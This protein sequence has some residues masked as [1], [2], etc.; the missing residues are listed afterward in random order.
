M[1]DLLMLIS[2]PKTFFCTFNDSKIQK[3]IVHLKHHTKNGNCSSVFVLV[4]VCLGT[5]LWSMMTV[6]SKINQLDYCWGQTTFT[7]LCG[8][9]GDMVSRNFI[10]VECD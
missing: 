3:T 2:K 9:I 1:N 10:L 7:P 4:L 8:R 6:C 5:N